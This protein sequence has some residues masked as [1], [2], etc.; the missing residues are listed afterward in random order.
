MPFASFG[1]TVSGIAVTCTEVSCQ[2]DATALDKSILGGN[3]GAGNMT[4]LSAWIK[5]IAATVPNRGLP[6]YGRL[7][8]PFV[9]L[10]LLPVLVPF[11]LLALASIPYFK[12]YPDRH[13][14]IGDAPE[15]TESQRKRLAHWRRGYAR[16]GFRQRLVRACRVCRRPHHASGKIGDPSAQI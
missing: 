1:S 12:L 3:L 5:H 13:M 15:A 8:A 4:P 16:L 14:N 11:G 6:W 9:F 2:G 10:V 7:L